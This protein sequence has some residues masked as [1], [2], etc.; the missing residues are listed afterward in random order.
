[1]QHSNVTESPGLALISWNN[2]ANSG[3]RCG[4]CSRLGA[5]RRSMT[6]SGVGWTVSFAT[7]VASPDVLTARTI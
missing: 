2:F 7:H 5:I 6:S 1:M 4:T 3:G